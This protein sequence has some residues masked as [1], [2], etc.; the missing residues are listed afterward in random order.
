MFSKVPVTGR[1]V[2]STHLPSTSLRH[3]TARVRL[4]SFVP[5]LFATS[6]TDLSPTGLDAGT[7]CW[8]SLTL[9][10]ISHSSPICLSHVRSLVSHK[11]FPAFPWALTGLQC[12]FRRRALASW[13]VASPESIHHA[14]WLQI[15]RAYVVGDSVDNLVAEDGW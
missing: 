12:L 7:H 3:R 10:I 8:D 15:H 14:P 4:F 2:V 9:F 13:W 1:R 5:H 11:R 6:F